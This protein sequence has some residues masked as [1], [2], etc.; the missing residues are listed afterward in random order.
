MC[1]FL[2]GPT[3]RVTCS[4]RIQ[5]GQIPKITSVLPYGY[6]EAWVLLLFKMNF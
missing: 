1:L 2:P 3:G 6:H 4:D 5:A